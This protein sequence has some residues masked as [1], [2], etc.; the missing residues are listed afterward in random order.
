MSS[1]GP[2]KH[3]VADNLLEQL[4]RL[5]ERELVVLAHLVNGRHVSRDPEQMYGERLTFG[6]RTADRVASFGGSWTF[7]F[8][9]VGLML[10]WIVANRNSARPFDP[11]PFILLNLVLSCLAALQAPIIMMSQNRQAATDRVAAQ[12][13]Y[14]VNL[15]A[16]LDILSLHTKL[17]EIRNVSLE[18]IA[19]NERQT[20]ILEQIAASL[21]NRE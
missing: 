15:K 1:E 7:I 3:S 12:Q 10:M 21:S 13:D 14:Q 16:E 11:Y 19:Q 17:E 9:F 6:Q 20:A 2:A 5:G 8:I 4:R 18:L